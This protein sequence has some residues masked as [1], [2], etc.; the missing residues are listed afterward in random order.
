MDYTFMWWLSVLTL[1]VAFILGVIAGTRPYRRRRFITFSKCVS[2]GIFLSG[3]VLIFALYYGDTTPDSIFYGDLWRSLLTALQHTMRIF[4]LDGGYA[5]LMAQA[6]QWAPDVRAMYE[7]YGAILYALAPFTTFGFILT[8][9][10]NMSSHLRYWLCR[11]SFWKRTHVFSEL[12]ERTLTLA[13]SLLEGSVFRFRHRAMNLLFGWFAH[14]VTWFFRPILVFT[15][16][17]EG[18]EEAHVDLVEEAREMGAILFRKDLSAVSHGRLPV[19][20]L[21]IYLISENEEEK[22]RHAEAMLAR[23]FYRSR[24]YLVSD[25]VASQCFFQSY[26]GEERSAMHMEAIRIDDI[27]FLIYHSLDVNGVRLFENAVQR[28]DEKVISAAIVGF[29]RYGASM[30][31]ALLWY[32][33]LPG[34][35]VKIHVFDEHEDAQSRFETMCPDLIVGPHREVDGD[36]HYSISFDRAVAGTREFEKKMREL[37]DI[38]YLF[39]ALGT[40]E[41]NVATALSIRRWMKECGRT[42]DIETVVYDSGLKRRISVAWPGDET[43]RRETDMKSYDLHVIGDME[44]FYSE[45]TVIASDLIRAGFEVHCRYES[46]TG[47]HARN[48]FYM[49]DYNFFSSVSKALHERM[50]TRLG[51]TIPGVDK[52]WDSRTAEEKLA[53]GRVE[54]VRWNAYMRTEGYRYS[55][56]LE[57][58]SRDNVAKLHNRLVPVSLLSDDDLRLDA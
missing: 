12:N 58:S 47:T 19:R 4:V 22:L 11:I 46:C 28:G 40:D 57:K 15:D 27:R 10:K 34:Y 9:V 51:L 33:Q 53:I 49:N 6:A 20:R 7:A 48:N 21:S 56:S 41:Q 35:T 42:P 36:M 18:T 52:P 55:G 14:L 32:C 38:T 26:T 29:G 37:G 24:L 25:S 17:S 30:L 45:S 3:F 39:V 23:D 1:A 54:H 31:K 13:G 16:V 44:S 50:R 8:F 5:G 43:D 2:A